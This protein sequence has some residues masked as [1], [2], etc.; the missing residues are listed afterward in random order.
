MRGGHPERLAVGV[1][2]W[3]YVLGR[4]TSGMPGGHDL[5][6][7]SEIV[8]ALIFVWIAFKS[9]RWW[10]F[11]ACAALT[12]CALVFLLEW[13]HPNLSEY[14]AISARLGLWFVIH[15][16]LLAGVAERWLA[17]EVAVSS[18][19]IWRPQTSRSG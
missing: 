12:L 16:A 14:A 6:G 9:E 4:S 17:G 1:L 15:L 3:D 13:T 18:R 7:I 2:F 5:V 10:L 11:V 8:V 19:S